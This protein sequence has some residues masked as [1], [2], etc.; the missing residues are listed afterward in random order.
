MYAIR[1]L[2]NGDIQVIAGQNQRFTDEDL[3]QLKEKEDII[4]LRGVI[5][6]RLIRRKQSNPLIQFGTEDDGV[7][8]FNCNG[9]KFDTYW[10]A[11]LM[12]VA[13]ETQKHNLKE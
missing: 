12:N 8:Y 11:D 13:I 7:L 2:D 4:Y 1:H 5:C 3:K 6:A 10:I 9:L